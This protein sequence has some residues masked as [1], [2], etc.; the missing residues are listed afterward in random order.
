[1]DRFQLILHLNLNCY[2]ASSLLPQFKL[3][4]KKGMEVNMHSQFNSK[5]K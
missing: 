2:Q 5:E 1:M 4:K 3:N